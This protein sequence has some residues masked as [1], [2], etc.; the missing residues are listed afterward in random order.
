MEICDMVNNM[1][2]LNELYHLELVN[3]IK[4]DPLFS[5]QSNELTFN[6][7]EY[8]EI[9]FKRLKKIIE[10]KFVDSTNIMDN[11]QSFYQLMNTLHAYD[12]SLA[13]KFG[14]NF[15]LFGTGLIR[16]GGEQQIKQYLIDLTKGNILGCLAIT[17]IGH[18]SDLKKLETIAT[19][20][21]NNKY[22]ILNTPTYSAIKCWIGNAA[23]HSTHAIVF[24]QLQYKNKSM[25]LHVFIVKLRNINEKEPLSN[26]KIKDNG[27]KKGLNGLDNGTIIFNNLI[28]PR[29]GLLSNFGF[30]DENGKYLI[31]DEYKNEKTRFAELLSTLS[32][33]RGI[34]AAGANIVSSK[35]LFIACKYSQKRRQF[36]GKNNIDKPLIEYTTHQLKLVP[37]IAKT[38]ALSYSIE[39]M[40]KIGLN[41]YIKINKISK[42]VHA[43]S[44]GIK[45]ISSEHAEK[46]CRIARICCGGHGYAFKNELSKMH[47]DIDIYQTFEGDNTLLRQE[48]CKY[49]LS[50][51]NDQIGNGKLNQYLYFLKMK[52]TQHLKL[53]NKFIPMLYLKNIQN[54]NFIL[55]LLNYRETHLII[56]LVS[57]LLKH[58]KDGLESFEAW[59]RCLDVVIAIADANMNRQIFEIF[60]I[61]HKINEKDW[62]LL[63]GYDLISENLDW[64][65]MNN[66]ITND[67]GYQF[68]QYKKNYCRKLVEDLDNI[69]EKFNMP[70]IF[71]NVPMLKKYNGK[72]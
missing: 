51:L 5:K 53:I 19:W 48:V 67:Y 59:N 45:I 12:L 37:L 57:D 35:A 70:E 18:G 10:C 41:D 27:F 58:I 60:L 30:I 39:N 38:L 55:E 64:Y 6:Y 29:E 33:G 62:V 11:P 20:D 47:N 4:N 61:E 15:G 44:S 25:G 1:D 21:A 71:W 42:R 23:C 22:F 31:K 50:L 65:L 28:V 40:K 13:I 24:A 14:V 54:P 16:L 3:L 43:L 69:F 49:T 17:E 72:L 52:I 8:R 66:I 7:K 26:I 32:G 56:A 63:F 68:L 34:L 9:T 36:S 46:S 2:N